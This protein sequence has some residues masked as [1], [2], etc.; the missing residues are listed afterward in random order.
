MITRR[1]LVGGMALAL[2]SML[3]VLTVAVTPDAEAK[4]KKGRKKKGGGG[5]S[6]GSSGY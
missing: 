1:G 5:S 4:K 6:G 3:G 2:A